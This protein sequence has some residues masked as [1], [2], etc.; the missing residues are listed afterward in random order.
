[1]TN[2]SNI[3]QR[4]CIIGDS[5]AG[6][7][8][9]G[10]ESIKNEFPSV[11]VTF[12][13]IARGK[14]KHLKNEGTRL[15]FDRPNLIERIEMLG[16]SAEIDVS[17]YDLFLVVGMM[18][19]LHPLILFQREHALPGQ[20]DNSKRQHVS[21]EMYIDAWQ[22]QFR[23]TPMNNVLS[24]LQTSGIKKSYVIFKPLISNEII[25]QNRTASR[26][27]TELMNDAADNN[28]IWS[29]IER[30][31]KGVLG[32]NTYIPQPAETTVGG[33]LTQAQ[34]SAG[35]TR[36]RSDEEQHDDEDIKHMN[37]EYGAVCLRNA[38]QIM[39]T[40]GAQI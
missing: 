11:E 30:S 23:S 38:L 9:L 12:L 21:E 29:L 28:R 35:S 37:G 16:F 18:E 3:K 25:E 39:S 8:K 1:M 33:L 17:E 36:L 14:M 26:I 34:Y 13:A 7:F 27:Y 15:Y 10:W 31:M 2:K 4:I 40:T 6:A 20:P 32:E 24:K 5:H 22:E 19:P